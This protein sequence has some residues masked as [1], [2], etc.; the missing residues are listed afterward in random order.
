MRV[1]TYLCKYLFNFQLSF[2]LDIYL[3]VELLDHMVILC[4]TFWGITILFFYSGCTIWC[5]YQQY[6]QGSNSSTFSSA[7]IFL[8]FF[9]NINGREMVS[10]FGFDLFSL[11]ISDVKPLF[12]CLLDICTSSLEKYMFKTFDYF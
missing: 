8:P 10:H 5:S 2:L 7:L 11:K 3:E 1:W 4:L 12:M 6:T 9:V